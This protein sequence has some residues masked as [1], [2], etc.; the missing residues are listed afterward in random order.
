MDWRSI[1]Q[2]VQ[3]SQ[4]AVE[5]GRA[6]RARRG[7]FLFVS[8]PL[9]VD[10]ASGPVRSR[11][12][13]VR[14]VVTVKALAQL[15]GGGGGTARAGDIATRL[16]RA[17]ARFPPSSP[18]SLLPHRTPSFLD[19]YQAAS[20]SHLYPH[21]MSDRPLAPA[22]PDVFSSPSP[23]RSPPPSTTTS[24]AAVGPPRLAPVTLGWVD[25][26]ASSLGDDQALQAVADQDDSVH[27]GA[28]RSPL[29]PR[30]SP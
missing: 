11:L 1:A 8:F 4:C 14:R 28:S 21:A 25:A 16:D 22:V 10:L 9:L 12:H 2:G 23:P 18:P 19:L 17:G 3:G 29:A 5:P 24:S 27:S 7:R 26:S 30:S 20:T 6:R 15:R 13:R